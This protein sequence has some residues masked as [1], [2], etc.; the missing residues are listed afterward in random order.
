MR[1]EVIVPDDSVEARI[2][3]MLPDPQAFLLG[4]LRS[5]DKQ[6]G[7][8]IPDYVAILSRAKTSSNLFKTRE[9]VDVYLR[10]LRDEW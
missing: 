3:S 6:A 4:L 10:G 9:D 1:L 7:D 8:P 2:L 5:E